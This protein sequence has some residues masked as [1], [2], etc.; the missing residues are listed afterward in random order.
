[1]TQSRINIGSDGTLAG[2]PVSMGAQGGPL[3]YIMSPHLL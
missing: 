3:I 2:A 1:M